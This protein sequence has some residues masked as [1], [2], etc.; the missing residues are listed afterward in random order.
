MAAESLDDLQQ[1]LRNLGDLRMIVRTM[2]A[3]SAARIRQYEDAVHA[4]CGYN[5]TVELG[6]EGVLR[7][8]PRQP[9]PGAPSGRSGCLGLV[10][11]GSDHGMCGRF[12]EQITEFGLAR[13]A[14]ASPRHAPL[15][16]TLGGRV[17][18]NLRHAGVAI[19]EE[20]EV[21]A[22]PTQITS[23]VSDL[24]FLIDGWREHQTLHELVLCFNRHEPGRPYVSVA[25]PLLPVD[26]RRFQQPHAA[27]WPSRRLPVFS[28][29][30]RTLLRRLINQYLFVSM[31]R[32]CAESQASEHAARL[33]AMHAAQRNIDDRMEGLQTAFRRTRQEAITAELLDVVG[34]FEAVSSAPE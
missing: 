5:Q 9:A 7:T 25:L 28:M 22:S 4:L 24:L 6:L 1:Q 16:A 21:P 3:L 29:E 10:V 17:A 19:Q 32:A 33:D 31:F 12:N 8:L 11:F 2:K 27:P 13:L 14:A 34:G 30:S 26:L 20:I 23:T 18:D 15:V